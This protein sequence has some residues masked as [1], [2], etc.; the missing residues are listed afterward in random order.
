MRVTAAMCVTIAGSNGNATNLQRCDSERSIHISRAAPF[1]VAFA[2]R[3][4]QAVE[5]EIV[6]KPDTHNEPCILQ[7]HDILRFRL[8]FLSVEIGRYQA[9]RI[10]EVT[11]HCLGQ[12]A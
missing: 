3:F 11:A 12:T 6:I 9:D 4:E 1:D 7:P 10:D 8:I 2:G 5:P